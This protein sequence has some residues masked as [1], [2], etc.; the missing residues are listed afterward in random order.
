MLLLAATGCDGFPFAGESRS[1]YH[2]AAPQPVVA[3]TLGSQFDPTAAGTITGQVTWQGPIPDVPSLRGWVTVGAEENPTHKVVRENPNAPLVDPATK[4]V[5]NAVVYLRSISPERSRPWDQPP[6]C[7][8]QRDYRL[9]ICQGDSDSHVGFVRRG[10]AIDMVSRQEVFHCLRAQGAAF[11]SLTFPDAGLSC[12]RRLEKKGLV[13]LSSAADYFWMHGY[14]F[15]DDHP[16][17]T[18]TGAQGQFTLQ[19]VPPGN[20]EVICWMPNWL[21]ERHER[22]QDPTQV[23]RLFFRPPVE[24]TNQVSLDRAGTQITH[25]VMRSELFQPRAR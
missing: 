12:S 3:D 23:V 22:D 4:G 15:V 6:V 21:E 5:G 10:T 13:E 1:E 2:D 8:E 14:L 11:F 18:R 9:H 25:F 24:V 19:G 17:Y 16:Y 7:V 20:H